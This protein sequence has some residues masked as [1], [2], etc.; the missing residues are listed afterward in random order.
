[1]NLQQLRYAVEV[2]K[3][4]SITKASKNLFMGQPN[5]SKA[6]KELEIE[7]GITLFNRTTR[8]AIPTEDG[9]LFLKYASNILTQMDE[10][11]SFYKIN[12]DG[13][14]KL[15]LSVPRA[16]YIS[17]LF[18]E[19]INSLDI[20]TTSSLDIRYKETSAT[21]TINDISTRECDL[22]IIRYPKMYEDYFINL[23]NKNHIS[24]EKLS[25]FN[26]QI[27]FHNSHPF[28]S[29]DTIPFDILDN[30]IELRQG[31]FKEEKLTLHPLTND[32]KTPSKQ[33]YIYIYDRS[34]QFDILEKVTGTY[35]W[36]SPIPDEIMD[37]HGLVSKPCS[38]KARTV[39]LIIYSHKD[40][41]TPLELDLISSLKSQ[42]SFEV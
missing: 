29:Y 40:D 10:L 11:E 33:K 18:C 31:D 9:K 13:K 22:G 26:M 19:F 4:T 21:T 27:L 5:L 2:E 8:G 17:I 7:L 12:S 1:M 30:Y 39:D 24:Y 42:A 32:F 28:N 36:A 6:L 34:S 35:L 25:E 38:L 14:I 16:T 15:N 41:L 20:D 23:L 37:K 3:S